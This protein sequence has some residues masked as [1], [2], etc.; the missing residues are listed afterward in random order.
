LDEIKVDA[1]TGQAIISSI[2]ESN[3]LMGKDNP[4]SLEFIN[5][6]NYNNYIL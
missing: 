2:D 4:K 3:D 6:L 5:H 1:L